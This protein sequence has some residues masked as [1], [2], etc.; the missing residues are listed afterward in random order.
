MTLQEVIDAR[1]IKLIKDYYLKSR[2]VEYLDMI[3]LIIK[4]RDVE[5]IKQCVEDVDLV[6]TS[7]EKIELIL[8][9]K[10]IEYIKKLLGEL[11]ALLADK[12]LCE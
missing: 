6:D 5:F 11:D 10:D 3:E 9:T 4:T 7:F 8:A 1:D 2:E 12:N